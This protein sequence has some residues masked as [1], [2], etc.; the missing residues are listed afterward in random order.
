MSSLI[1]RLF[2][3]GAARGWHN[4]TR[5]ITD[6]FSGAPKAPSSSRR[7][8]LKTS[9]AAAAILSLPSSL[10]AQ[11][12]KYNRVAVIGG[13]FGGL[14][15]ADTLV[16]AG[17]NVTVFE[18]ESRVGGRVLTDRR[19]IANQSVE[20]GAEFI[21][22]NHPTWFALAKKHN[23]TLD[24]LGESEGDDAFILE[25]KLIR[26]LKL[27]QLHDEI[28]EVTAKLCELAKPIDS[29]RPFDAP[30][31]ADLDAMSVLEW[32]NAQTVSE[33]AKA[34]MVA[35][36]ESDN[37][38]T[39][40]RMSFLAYLSMISGGGLGDYFELSE[41]HHAA[42]GNDSLASAI[43]RSLGQRVRLRTAINK[44]DLTQPVA[45][46]TAE[47][48]ARFE[49]DAVV[50]A[51]P[52]TAWNAIEI[53]PALPR[54]MRPQFGSNVKLIVK[55]DGPFW[56]PTGLSPDVYGDGLI[57]I[58][59]A[60]AESESDGIAYTLF[61][62]ADKTTQLREMPADQRTRRACEAM[63][64]AFPDLFAK[65]KK[66]LFVDWPS[67][68]RVR[69]SYSFPAP[70]QVTRFGPTLVDG[71]TDAAAPLHF[72]GEH[73]SYAFIGYMEGALSSGVRVAKTLLTA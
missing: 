67:M 61:N 65:V 20:L 70:G 11:P 29:I 18:A 30:N 27:K 23:I 14:A 47:D 34:V 39:A 1:R 37:G 62:G 15:C 73:T 64:P 2:R 72:V 7:N 36:E 46:L 51:I 17:I 26:G 40:G 53:D 50:L 38:V 48:G 41:T 3:I 60:A 32:I 63:S 8:F 52:P 59:W 25:G 71:I 19:L 13:G 5:E 57:Q 31:A 35:Y 4:R 54:R 68:P 22:T 33:Q 42:G 45:R 24:E 43:A 49:A 9:A 21:G 16:A 10:L 56:K 28:D 55:C 69:G 58:G 66:D 44:I 12:R 6:S